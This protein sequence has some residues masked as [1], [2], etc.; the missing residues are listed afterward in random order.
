MKKVFNK[1]ISAQ[2]VFLF[3]FGIVTVSSCQSSNAN[4]QTKT[5]TSSAKNSKNMNNELENLKTLTWKKRIVLVREKTDAGLNQLN[6][7]KDE[8]ND[9]DVVWLRLKDDELKTNFEG[10]LSKKLTQ[11]LKTNYFDKFDEEVFLIGKDGTIKSKD[12][13]L[14]LKNYFKQIDSMP[15]RQREMEEN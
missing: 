12:D 9:R 15:M 2:F 1:F 10:G 4:S 14:N 5:E 11:H 6:K 7:A 13:K 8:V 3:L